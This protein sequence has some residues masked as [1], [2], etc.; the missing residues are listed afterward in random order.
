MILLI[1]S[2]DSFTNNLSQLIIDNTGKEVI[3]IHNDTFKPNEYEF[4]MEVY[5]PMFDYIVIGPGPG[6]PSNIEDV[7]IVRWILHYFG[8]REPEKAIPVLGICLGFNAHASNL[9]MRL[10]NLKKVR[11]GQI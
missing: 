2:Y 1:D 10:K 6:H 4:F 5:I 7:G 8:E 3:T 11:H 9:V